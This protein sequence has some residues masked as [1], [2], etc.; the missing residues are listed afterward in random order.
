MPELRTH[1]LGG[2]AVIEGVMM[3]GPRTYSV[4]VR[5][6]NGEIRIRDFPIAEGPLKAR[7]SRMPLV[8]GVVSTA[9][10][11]VIGL[12]AL[13]VSADEAAADVS[14]VEG[15]GAAVPPATNVG[16]GSAMAGTLV[17]AL[18]VA[19]LLFFILP[20]VLTRLAMQVLPAISG[21]LAFNL[22]DGL[23]RILVFV[24]YVLCLSG[25]RD[26]RRVFQYHGAEHKVINAYENRA[27]LVPE[28]VGEFP[29]LH[30]RCGTSFLLF[31][32]AAGIV[33]F[34][35]IPHGAPLSVKALM[36]VLLLP[37]I[38]GIAYE[39][40]RITAKK[41]DSS[42][43]RALMAPGLLLQRL[44]T[45]EPDLSQ[46]EVAIASFR[47]VAPGVRPEVCRAG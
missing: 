42:L 47:R 7:L 46:I 27:V 23:I 15:R 13:Q 38:A 45:R 43:F 10:M 22:A 34:S 16:G 6:Q 35:F 17:L 30:P 36:R 1:F 2:Q 25:V 24:A 32:M 21:R 33:V 11:L 41:G 28:R 26:I 37:V 5:K 19:V 3:K 14:P 18:L 20:L 40:L 9:A 44:T 31:V 4:A 8:R 29:R 39:V 12:R